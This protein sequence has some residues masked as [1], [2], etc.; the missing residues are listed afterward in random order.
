MDSVRRGAAGC[1]FLGAAPALGGGGRRTGGE[2]QKF[3]RSSFRCLIWRNVLRKQ[4]EDFS[5]NELRKAT[6]DF[7]AANKIGEGGFGSVFRGRLKDGTMVAVKL[8]SATSRQGVRESHRILAYNYLENNSLQHTLLGPGR[9]NIQF[10]WRARFKIADLTPKISDFGLAR[11]LPPNATHVSTRV[12][13][14]T[15]Y[16]APEYALRGQTWTSYEQGHLENIIDADLEDDLD[17]EQACRFLKV[18]L[19]CTQDATKLRPS[20]TDVVQMLLGEMDVSTERITKPSVIS[21]LG[22]LQASDQQRSS[23]AHSL[24]L[25]SSTTIEPSTS[26]SDATTQSSL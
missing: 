22:E 16:L 25:R 19:L 23:D 9:S 4:G 17:V 24:L 7:S 18:G 13:G 2:K 5:Y 14:T 12:A 20:M 11:L 10:N 3:S 8:L 26:S 1:W 21:G 15:G 6:H